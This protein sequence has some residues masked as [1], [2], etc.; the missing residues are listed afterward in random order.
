VTLKVNVKQFTEA[1]TR[2]ES[3]MAPGMT[4]AANK[5]SD[6]VEKEAINEAPVDTGNLRGSFF[7]RYEKEA[8]RVRLSF[9][10]SAAYAWFVHEMV[11]L[12]HVVG[13]AQFLIDPILRNAEKLLGFTKIEVE[14]AMR[15]GAKK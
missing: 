4:R 1:V 7:R 5:F 12:N 6:L 14:N 13:K 8:F 10:F 2:I 15:K 9:G 3:A 11:H